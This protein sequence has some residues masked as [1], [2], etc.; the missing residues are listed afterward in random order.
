MYNHSADFNRNV[1]LQPNTIY[2]N[3]ESIKVSHTEPCQ[4]Y[5]PLRT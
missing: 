3:K 4:T 5:Y 2:I 1:R